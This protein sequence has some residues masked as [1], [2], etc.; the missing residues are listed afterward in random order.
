V[1]VLFSDNGRLLRAFGADITYWREEREFLNTIKACADCC[2]IVKAS[3]CGRLSCSDLGQCRISGMVGSGA[4]GR[5]TRA[6]APP[7]QSM[8]RV[9]VWLDR[10][11]LLRCIARVVGR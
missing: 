2:G 10:K 6:Q 11:R 9:V 1:E 4:G 3:T 5:S 7:T 8:R